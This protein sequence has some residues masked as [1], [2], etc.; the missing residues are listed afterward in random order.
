MR[1]KEK[2]IASEVELVRI[3]DSVD[4]GF[5]SVVWMSENGCK[6]QALRLLSELRRQTN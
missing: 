4:N 3:P 2:A 6:P 5:G 1:L